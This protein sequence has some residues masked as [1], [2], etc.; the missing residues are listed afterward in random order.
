MPGSA[1]VGKG[2]FQVVRTNTE[3]QRATESQLL[4]ANIVTNG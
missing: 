1:D 3:T 2:A 4:V